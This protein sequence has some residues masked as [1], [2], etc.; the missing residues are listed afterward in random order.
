MPASAVGGTRARCGGFV[1]WQLSASLAA[2]TSLAAGV[3]KMASRRVPQKQEQEEEPRRQEEAEQEPHRQE[4]AERE[5]EA[6]QEPQPQE[7]EE[8]E[9]PRVS[10]GVPL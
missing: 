9:E 10:V 1:G 6:E 5:E 8:Q 2:L 3:P 7:K 4:E